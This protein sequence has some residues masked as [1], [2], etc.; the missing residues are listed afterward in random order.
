MSPSYKHGI[1]AAGLSV[2]IAGIVTTPIDVEAFTAS[3]HHSFATR[4][5]SA[6]ILKMASENGN[7]SSGDSELPVSGSF[8]N[9][10]PPPNT[11]TPMEDAAAV[12]SSNETVLPSFGGEDMEM[13]QQIIQKTKVSRSESGQGFSKTTSTSDHVT[14]SVIQTTSTDPK[15]SFVGIGKPL[16]DLQNP[17]YDENG[18]TLYADETTGEKKRVFE[19]LV[20]YP[21]VFKMKIVGQDDENETFAPEIVEAVAKSC[22]VDLSMVKNTKRKNGKWTSVTVHAPVKSADMLYA[23]YASIDENPRV[24]F[25]F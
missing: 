16:N 7:G 20:E 18:Y 21:A 23:L 1:A 25:K 17:E 4:T 14:S 3:Q 12:E 2:L 24:K 8:F 11:D 15:D 10:V 13:F 9:A 5:S 19:A 6:A 22:G